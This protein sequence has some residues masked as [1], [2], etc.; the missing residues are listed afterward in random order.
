MLAAR[1]RGLGTCWTTVHLSEEEEVA[2]ILGIPYAEI[3]QAALI[4]VAY[5]KGTYFKAGRRKPFDQFVHVNGW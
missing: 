4:P 1:V 5:T 3:Q 2:D